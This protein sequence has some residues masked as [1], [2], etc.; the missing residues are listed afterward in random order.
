[1]DK[2][3]EKEELQIITEGAEETDIF[4]APEKEET[5]LEKVISIFENY[6]ARITNWLKKSIAMMIIFILIGVA[7]GLYIAKIIYDFRMDEISTLAKTGVAGYVHKG[8][9]YDVKL[10]P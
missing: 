5:Q 7:G 2:V 3:T 8:N 9:I 10:R 6:G 1:M 4:T